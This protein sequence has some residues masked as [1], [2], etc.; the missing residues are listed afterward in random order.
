M[1]VLTVKVEDYCEHGT[2]V[3]VTILN[4]KGEKVVA[5]VQTIDGIHLG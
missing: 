5:Y 4:K 2:T 3:G 1:K